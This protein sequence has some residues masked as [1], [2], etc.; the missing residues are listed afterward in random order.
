M[1]FTVPVPKTELGGI[2]ITFATL[3][4]DETISS[5]P[6]PI[7][8]EPWG[9]INYAADQFKI[10]PVPVTIRELDAD[11][12][13]SDEGT[14]A[15]YTGNNELKRN[16]VN[17][18]F[19]RNLDLDDV[20]NKTALWQYEIP[21]SVTPEGVLYPES[22]EHYPF[23]DQQAEVCTYVI[24]SSCTISTPIEYLSLIHI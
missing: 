19:T 10:D 14:V 2:V 23:A 16:Y 4:P 13:Q 8:S 1:R 12:A 7:L 18:G 22:L 9:A 15:F 20:A 5:Q 17:Y 6:H 21:A 11:C 3:K 24:N